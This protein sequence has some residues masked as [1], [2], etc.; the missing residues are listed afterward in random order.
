[1][2]PEER[3][4]KSRKVLLVSSGLLLLSVVVGISQKELTSGGLLPFHL[5]K[6]G[7]IPHALAILVL[8][9]IYNST[10]CWAQFTSEND[11]ISRIRS[12]DFVVIISIA[13]VALATFLTTALAEHLGSIWEAIKRFDNFALMTTVTIAVAMFGLIIF[14]YAKR[15]SRDLSSEKRN[16]KTKLAILLKE[17][18]WTLDFN[19][20]AAGA[21]KRISF[22]DDGTI[23]DGA[24]E[25]EC[26]WAIVDNFLE[27]Y[28][29]DGTLQN[30][31]TV[32][33]GG[34][35]WRSTNDPE[36]DA[37]RR[38]IKDQA[39]HAADVQSHAA[40]GDALRS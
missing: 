34:S 7:Y 24:N 6:P 19:P 16:T 2:P 35:V 32:E 13:L 21:R 33:A 4:L 23:G 31:F 12:R 10:V 1:M 25:N 22:N 9:G 40:F 14:E 5:D 8:Y 15:L 20:N 17:L 27:I 26:S 29:I 3:Y 36:A 37:V 38:G 11:Q 30:R 18:E 39:I 28:K